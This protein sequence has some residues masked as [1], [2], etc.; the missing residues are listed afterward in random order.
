GGVSKG[1]SEE[2][3]SQLRADAKSTPALETR[4]RAVEDLYNN[5]LPRIAAA[6]DSKKQIASENE[7]TARLDALVRVYLNLNPRYREWMGR[8][9]VRQLLREF[10]SSGTPALTEAF[11]RGLTRLQP[12]ATSVDTLTGPRAVCLRAIE[13]FGGRLS[14]EEFAQSRTVSAPVVGLLT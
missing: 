4:M 12:S 1:A 10:E 14:A 3:I 5:T 6:T 11:R 13:F 2:I 9:G 8:W 7:S